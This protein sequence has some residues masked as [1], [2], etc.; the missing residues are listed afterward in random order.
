MIAHYEHLVKEINRIICIS[1]EH[2]SY[3]M[4]IKDED[5]VEVYKKLIHELRAIEIQH[6]EG[7]EYWSK[8]RE[9]LE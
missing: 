9:E 2:L 4:K 7:L 6:M 1:E 8:R 3:H 5:N